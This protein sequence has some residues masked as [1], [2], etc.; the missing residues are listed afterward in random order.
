M[1]GVLNPKVLEFG[2]FY[3]NGHYLM[4]VIPPPFATDYGYD[5]KT[6][7]GRSFNLRDGTFVGNFSLENHSVGTIYLLVICIY[8][9]DV[10][11]VMILFIMLYG[12]IQVVVLKLLVMQ[13]K[14]LHLNI[15]NQR[16]QYDLRFLKTLNK[17]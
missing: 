1:A 2:S 9:K 15:I 3:T 8:Q 17:Q 16:F 12:T 10:R 11:H 14:D 7:L 13:M 5:S 6:Y 4:V